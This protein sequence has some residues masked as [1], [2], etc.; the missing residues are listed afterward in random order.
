[1]TCFPQTHDFQA[2]TRSPRVAKICS[3]IQVEATSSCFVCVSL[4]YFLRFAVSSS[5]VFRVLFPY[6]CFFFFLVH[7]G[8]FFF[9]RIC[10]SRFTFIRSYHSLSVYIF[11]HLSV[12]LPVYMYVNMCVCILTSMPFVYLSPY[13]CLLYLIMCSSAF[14][15][16]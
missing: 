7:D 9:F 8:F 15:S 4:R 1:M 2:S 10:C 6:F 3:L 12:C 13:L 16:V 14:V 11:V 5:S